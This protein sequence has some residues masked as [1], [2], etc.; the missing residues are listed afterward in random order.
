[1]RL[2]QHAKVVAYEKT[3]FEGQ[4][5]EFVGS[6]FNAPWKGNYSLLL[7]LSDGLPEG[8]T[9][10]DRISS[11]KVIAECNNADAVAEFFEDSH[12]SGASMQLHAGSEIADLNSLV[13]SR[14]Q[15]S[16]ATR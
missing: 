8:T 4:A 11:I 3:N 10:N 5:V 1:M 14:N 13:V 12:F 2:P 9:W 16:R 6:A 7:N 15:S